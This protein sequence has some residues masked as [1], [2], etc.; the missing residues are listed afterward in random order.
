MAAINDFVLEIENIKKDMIPVIKFLAEFEKQFLNLILEKLIILPDFSR[1]ENE[2]KQEYENFHDFM[3]NLNISFYANI[4]GLDKEFRNYLYMGENFSIFNISE[5]ALPVCNYVYKI[6]ETYEKIQENSSSYKILQLQKKINDVS[7]NFLKVVN[8]NIKTSGIYD[9]HKQEGGK[10]EYDFASA[11]LAFTPQIL[12]LYEKIGNIANSNYEFIYSI[13][14]RM[15][16]S[17]EIYDK[18][19]ETEGEG[20]KIY[21][22]KSFIPQILSVYEK[23]GEVSKIAH[24]A[25]L[26]IIIPNITNTIKTSGI[27]E[28]E[29]QSSGV[30]DIKKIFESLES[31]KNY[32][33]L[34]SYSNPSF[35]LEI[36]KTFEN[37]AKENIIEMSNLADVFK[38][39]E[40]FALIQSAK[41]GIPEGINYTANIPE[42]YEKFKIFSE[43]NRYVKYVNEVVERTT[44]I[45]NNN[46]ISSNLYG[47]N[48]G[49][50]FMNS[51]ISYENAKIDN[52]F[53]LISAT[54][55][56]TVPA[57]TINKTINNAFNISITAKS[58]SEEQELRE[59]GKKIGRIINEEIRRAGI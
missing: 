5:M 42:I 25:I 14:N 56:S 33:T 3:K 18:S 59:L 37:T 49:S 54:A 44:S 11:Y 50:E 2:K 55:P 47:S 53:S 35:A 57:T 13:I 45:I 43:E 34:T 32:E 19:K 48:T 8:N 51:L 1:E 4:Q 16:K 6:P 12:P 27:Y 26:N 20:G 17:H 30:L 28:K 7:N 21:E 58:T 24:E 15:Y 40:M 29:T 22:Q 23:I 31:K 52:A 46:Y 41:P 36:H 38:T 9:P 10:Y 39:N